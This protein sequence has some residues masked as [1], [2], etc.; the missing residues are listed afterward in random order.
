MESTDLQRTDMNRGHEPERG[1]PGRFDRA[2]EGAVEIGVQRC[3]L[4]TAK[5]G[6]TPARRLMGSPEGAFE[7]W[8]VYDAETVIVPTAVGRRVTFARRPPPAE[9]NSPR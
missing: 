9:S 7:P 2:S 3:V 4:S 1:H 6:G 8:G 5:A